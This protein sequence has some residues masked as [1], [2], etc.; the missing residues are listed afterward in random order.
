MLCDA[1]D[2]VRGSGS[3]IGHACRGAAARRRGREVTCRPAEC[4]F[5][6]LLCDFKN[7]T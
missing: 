5:P 2:V 7:L 4:T 1:G 6:P 3:V